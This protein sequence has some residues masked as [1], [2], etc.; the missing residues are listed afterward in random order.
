MLNI[1]FGVQQ[2]V[3][4]WLFALIAFVVKLSPEMCKFT[5]EGSFFVSDFRTVWILGR[6]SA[7]D[8]HLWL[9]AWLIT[10][11]SSVVGL[12]AVFVCLCI[13]KSIYACTDIYMHC[14]STY[15]SNM[16]AACRHC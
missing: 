11:C 3:A 4:A 8:V 1:Y 6:F 10:C 16:Q 9:E 12:L 2:N 7:L 13:R 14:T 5:L 15:R